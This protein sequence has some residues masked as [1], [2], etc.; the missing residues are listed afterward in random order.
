MTASNR[1]PWIHSPF[2]D[3]A[4]I[5]AP[6]LVATAL[7]LV[8]IGTGHGGRGLSIWMWAILIIGV[9][10][11]HVYST[12]FRTYLDPIERRRLSGWLILTP[13]AGWVLGVLLY[14]WSA[15]Y[16][17]TLLAYAAV[18][19]FMRQ[20]YGF[21]MIYARSERALPPICLIVDKCAIYAATLG[22]LI[23][24]HTHMPR[25]FVW[26]IDGDFLKLPGQLWPMIWP[27]Y[28]AV[29]AIYL[30]KECWLVVAHRSVNLPRNIIVVGT[31]ASWYVGIVAATGDLVFTMTNVVAHGI[32]Y[33]AL[34]FVYAKG[35]ERQHPEFR[36][37]LV[38]FI[39]AAIAMLI[40]FAFVEEGLWDGLVWR[41]HL[42]L[43]P[44]F[45][46]LPQINGD[47]VLAIVVPLLTL[48][49]L[50]HYIIDGVIWRLRTHPEWRRTLFWNLQ[51]AAGRV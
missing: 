48:P 22:P 8:L 6:A 24:W 39:P 43:F 35:E 3:G 5:L 45:A 27:L 44:M 34:T 28:L 1:Q 17:W 49:Q 51:P 29:L 31:A 46:W 18:F 13:L 7:S 10:V 32:P 20:Q 25:Q 21:L 9:D 37:R 11:A 23:Y 42:R 33:M 15:A 30:I 12:I 2:V 14:S 41:E 38:H 40:L 36:S 4:F 50:T 26:F 16:F 19:H 47:A